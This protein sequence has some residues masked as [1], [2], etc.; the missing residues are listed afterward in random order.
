[1][2][3]APSLTSM[4]ARCKN[5]L[6]ADAP[7]GTKTRIAPKPRARMTR[8]GHHFFCH[9]DPAQR[10]EGPRSCNPRFLIRNDS[11]IPFVRSLSVL[12]RIG[13]TN[14]NLAPNDHRL[15]SMRRRRT[16]GIIAGEPKLR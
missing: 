3:T 2:M 5:E 8:R 11:P 4:Q 7:A 9:P 15:H 13:M 1:M 10:G 12:W 6:I 16:L 14:E